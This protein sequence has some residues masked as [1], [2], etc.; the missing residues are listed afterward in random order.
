MAIRVVYDMV[1]QNGQGDAF[2]AALS[3]LAST[4]RA[5]PG[6]DGVDILRKQDNEDQ[7]LFIENWPSDQAYAEASQLVPKTA[8]APLKPLLGGPPARSVYETA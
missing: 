6:S 8:F 2:A 4:I 1:A 7:F 5:L 3:D